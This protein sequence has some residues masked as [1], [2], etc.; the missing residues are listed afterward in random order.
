MAGDNWLGIWKL[1]VGKSKFSPGPGP[2]GQAL[3]FV[4]TKDGTQLISDTINADG[5]TAHGTLHV[6]L[7][8]QGTSRG[9]E[10]RTPT[11]RHRRRLTTTAIENTWKKGGK[12]TMTAKVTVSA[13][14]K[15][16]T[17][18]QTGTNAKGQAVRTRPFTP[19]SRRPLFD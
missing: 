18:V 7:Q 3:K 12:A 11:R 5:T 2:K 10:I 19:D 6:P 9:P 15:T 13:D 8:R 16:L 14:G 1:E 4:E 17:V